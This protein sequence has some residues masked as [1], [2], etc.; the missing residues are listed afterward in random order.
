MASDNTTTRKQNNANHYQDLSVTDGESLKSEQQK[1]ACLRAAPTILLALA[2]VGT[3][4]AVYSFGMDQHATDEKITTALL[5]EN[6]VRITAATHPA[7]E[8]AIIPELQRHAR[9]KADK[10][11]DEN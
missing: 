6:G 10:S 7:H 8:N 4:F 9:L 2:L 3:N 11:S 1:R 5:H